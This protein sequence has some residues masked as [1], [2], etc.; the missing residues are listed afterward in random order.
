MFRMIKTGYEIEQDIKELKINS[1]TFSQHKL[2]IYID[3]FGVL[4]KQLY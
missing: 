4:I 2:D 3:V 1:K